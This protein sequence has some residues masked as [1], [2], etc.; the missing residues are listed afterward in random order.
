MAFEMGEI[1]TEEQIMSLFDDST[2]TQEGAK[3]GT[4]VEKETK[5]TTEEELPASGNPFDTEENP[6]SVGSEQNTKGKE[7]TPSSGTSPYVLSS[8]AKALKEE[9][10][11]LDLK[12]EDIEKIAKPEDFADVIEQQIQAKLDERQKRIDAALGNGVEPDVIRNYENTLRQLES[13]SEQQL[14]T[15]SEQAENLRKSIIY[16]DYLNKGFSEER[17]KR[18]VEKAVKDGTD[19]EDAVEALAS[20]KETVQKSY[21]DALEEAR[22]KDAEF[23][24]NQDKEAAD[25]KKSILE[26]KKFFGDLSLDTATRRKVLE[27]ISKPIYKDPETGETYTA[28]QKY[29]MDHRPEFLKYVGIIYTLTDGFKN[30]EGLTKEKVRTEAKKGLKELEQTINNTQRNGDGTLNFASG[31]D[32]ESYFSGLRLDL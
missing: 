29:E 14:K 28:I 2:E 15:E 26:D 10:I 19:I 4:P 17:A 32:S 13:I 12:D 18:A 9:G 24:K 23:K 1:L 8:L 27:N 22:V 31:V 16:R 6:E 7:D 11:L 5:E 3:E 20:I 21:D 25:I 30:L